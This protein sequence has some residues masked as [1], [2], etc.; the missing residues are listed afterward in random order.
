MTTTPQPHAAD[1][2]C[3]LQ[4]DAALPGRR[5]QSDGELAATLFS[6]QADEDA[7]QMMYLR[8]WNTRHPRTPWRVRLARAVYALYYALYAHCW[9]LLAVTVACIVAAWATWLWSVA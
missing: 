4:A 6:P 9:L 7:D 3:Q 1:V 2:Y 5:A 8:Q